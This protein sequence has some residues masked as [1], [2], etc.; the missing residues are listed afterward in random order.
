MVGIDEFSFVDMEHFVYV[1]LP[2][3]L[4]ADGI[5]FAVSTRSTKGAM[6]PLIRACSEG[7]GPYEYCERRP[8]C[9]E[10]M[11]FD[12]DEQ[13]SECPHT[14]HAKQP[15]A[16][17]KR[18]ETASHVT[19]ILGL[20]SA[21]AQENLNIIHTSFNKFFYQDRIRDLFEVSNHVTFDEPP[22]VVYVGIDP[23]NG[24]SCYLSGA[25][26]SHYR[27]RHSLVNKKIFFHFHFFYY[28]T[29]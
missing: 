17:E 3:S 16:N 5:L 1:Q 11:M 9:D 19:R 12:S 6:E 21:H 23:A 2:M 29:R 14:G 7:V 15:W 26:I 27:E 18:K 20:A 4:E 25:A 13:K 22:Q 10:C 24:G 8:I 28:K